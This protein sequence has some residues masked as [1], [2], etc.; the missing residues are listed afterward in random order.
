MGSINE[1]SLLVLPTSIGVLALAAILTVYGTV[2]IATA[3]RSRGQAR[4]ILALGFLLRGIGF[5]LG[6][7]RGYA[8]DLLAVQAG[9]TL[10]TAGSALFFSGISV[11]AGKSARLPLASAYI[12]FGAFSNAFTALYPQDLRLRVI[13]VSLTQALPVL[14]AAV[15]IALSPG[16]RRKASFRIA[17]AAFGATG[18]ALAFRAALAWFS[19]PDADFYGVGPFMLI[20]YADAIGSSL[21]YTLSFV[22]GL[23]SGERADARDKP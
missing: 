18:A 2:A 10:V 12:V 21:L 4:A 1:K 20:V 17:G 22:L 7:L 6:A 19:P 11:L 5:C 9:N 13:A 16:S 15:L 23:H 8:P 14:A 3:R